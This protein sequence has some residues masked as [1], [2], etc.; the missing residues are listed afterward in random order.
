MVKAA[1][2]KMSGTMTIQDMQV[3]LHNIG[4]DGSIS[5]EDLEIVMNEAGAKGEMKV[6]PVEKMMQLL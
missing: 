1:D 2:T 5:K 4:A 3:L 6:L